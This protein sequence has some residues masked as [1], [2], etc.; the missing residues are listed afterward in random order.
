MV[1][2]VFRRPAIDLDAQRKEW[3][4]RP[5]EE[6]KV[7]AI[8]PDYG[9]VAIIEGFSKGDDYFVKFTFIS[10]DSETY[11]TETLLYSYQ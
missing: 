8:I 9:E 7:G 11:Y 1:Y 3:T 6:I 10:G 5:A 4:E 2:K